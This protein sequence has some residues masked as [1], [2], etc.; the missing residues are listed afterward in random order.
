M[1]DKATAYQNIWILVPPYKL[2]KSQLPC[3]ATGVMLQN[4]FINILINVPYVMGSWVTTLSICG[5][6]SGSAT[7]HISAHTPSAYNNTIHSAD[8]LKKT[9]SLIS[10]R[11]CLLSTVL[12]KLLMTTIW[13]GLW[14]KTRSF[15]FFGSL[16][17][18]LY[19][20]TRTIGLSFV[21]KINKAITKLFVDVL[22]NH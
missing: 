20:I 5:K 17:V 11:F 16:H 8:I 21:T 3:K 22:M 9:C 10:K 19:F 18:D 15:F 2:E 4:P 14:R 6:K 7:N 13:E 12:V 1:L